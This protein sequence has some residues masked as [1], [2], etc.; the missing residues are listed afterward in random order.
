MPLCCQVL[1]AAQPKTFAFRRPGCAAPRVI[2]PN[3]G[4]LL[5]R[6]TRPA[7]VDLNRVVIAAVANAQQNSSVV[8][9]LDGIRDQ[10]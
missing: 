8:S 4:D 1:D 5:A 7:I 6:Q 2:L 10:V 9:V 3:F